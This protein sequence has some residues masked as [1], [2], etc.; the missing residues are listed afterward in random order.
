MSGFDQIC[1]SRAAAV[2]T[3]G[4]ERS[5]RDQL[6]GKV[7]RSW[8]LRR[9]R[10]CNSEPLRQEHIAQG[11]FREPSGRL[12]ASLSLLRRTT[13]RAA[14]APAPVRTA[15]VDMKV[16]LGCLRSQN[17]KDVGLQEARLEIP[18]RDPCGGH[19]RSLSAAAIPC[20]P[21]VP[22]P[23]RRARCRETRRS[24]FRV[25]HG[26]WP[27]GRGCLRRAACGRYRAP[28]RPVAPP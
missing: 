21:A 5:L 2:A 27:S 14:G 28:W 23:W 22:G 1:E 15:T 12:H 10:V 4:P 20:S 24:P 17:C 25:P 16:C 6:P 7:T 19:S 13:G 18:L 3:A 8:S 11:V 26:P 9:C